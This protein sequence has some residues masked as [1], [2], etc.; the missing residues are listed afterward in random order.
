MNLRIV[1]IMLACSRGESCSSAETSTN[2]RNYVGMQPK[3]QEIRAMTNL[4]IVEIMLACSP[5]RSTSTALN[6]YEQQ[7]LC[8]HVAQPG[9]HPEQDTSTNSRNYVGMQPILYH[10]SQLSDLRIV[11]I[12]LACSPTYAAEPISFY[13][14]IVEIMLA[15][16]RPSICLQSFMYLRIV[17]IMLACSHRIGTYRIRIST[18]SRNYVG[19]QPTMPSASTQT[20]ST[21]SRNYVGMQPYRLQSLYGKTST[22]SRNYVGMQPT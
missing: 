3:Q 22:N 13:L 12:M 10:Q 20:K 9:S 16:S 11:E 5:A 18:N 4:R 14:R 19:M 6:I 7:K 1:E 2:S 8:W 17:E 15:C 21:N